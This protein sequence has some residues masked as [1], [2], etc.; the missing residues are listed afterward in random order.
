D[1]LDP[2]ASVGGPLNEVEGLAYLASHG[3]PAAPHRHV[4]DADAAVAAW[5]A[6]GGQAVLKIVSRDLGHKSDVGGVRVGLRG[7][8][9]G[10]LMGWRG[11]TTAQGVSE[12][13]I[14]VEVERLSPGAWEQ[15]RS[16]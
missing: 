16:A 4:H 6:L 7:A 5:H 14:D 13:A 1:V 3:I 9:R 2:G 12:A 15:Q 8:D 10:R 11:R